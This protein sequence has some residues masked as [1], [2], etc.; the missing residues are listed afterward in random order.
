M[1]KWIVRKIV[2][3]FTHKP[4]G[5]PARS[6]EHSQSGK[7]GQSSDCSAITKVLQENEAYLKN[8]IGES[9]DIIYR[10]FQI[11]F[12]NTHALIVYVSGMVDTRVIDE[13]ILAPLMESMG[14]SEPKQFMKKSGDISM[15][16]ESGVFTSAVKTT[17]FWSEI[18]D[19]ISEGDTVLLVDQCAEALMLNTR[20]YESR[21]VSEPSTESE[22]RGPR[23]GFVENI[24]TNA[25]LIRRRIK[26][27]GLRFENMKIGERT[28]TIVSLIYIQ[29]LVNEA[30]LDEV[31]NRLGRIKT[32][33]VLGS[34]YIEEFIEDSP[35]S[36]FPL[37]ANTE[38]PDRACAAILEGRIAIL[39]DN[40]P[41]A[42]IVPAIF[43][44]FLQTSGDY[45]ER[46]TL[47]TFIRWIRFLALFLS[48]S[49]SPLYVLLTSF[50]QEMLPTA[51][52]LKI[53]AGRSG[54][55]FPAF[56][57]AFLMEIIL[58]IMKEAGLRMPKPLGQTVSIVGTLV[59]GQAAVS[60][61]LVSPLMV[62][63]IAVAAISSFAIPSYIMSNSLR[64]IR[65]PLLFLSALFGLLGYIA[66]L[67]V[68]SLHLMSLRSFGT[69]YLAPVIPF[70][71][72][73][74]VQDVFTRAPWWK[75]NKRSALARPQDQT[76]QNSN[77]LKPKP[78][79][80]EA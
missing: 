27:Y 63:V 26:D 41:F 30:L 29:S 52:A 16:V 6:A 9:F 5:S 7:I 40:T 62:I 25:A 11:P 53:A 21:A 3:W 18:C 38:R 34:Q 4:A 78:P 49:L 12:K 10:H 65:F 23:D 64:L 17:T 59:I 80:K 33:S 44:Q 48:I 72:N 73:S 2:G 61:G 14:L 50:H 20:K 60:A 75:M 8:T 13:T 67:M 24:Q 45:Y 1:F 37:V 54:V 31:R 57:E 36:I 79:K 32:D 46:F 28:K 58:E 70:N 43:W 66:G 56:V 68:I 55:P 19:A 74:S 77:D 15:L 76:R 51:L 42:L 71:S 39:V 22:I 35:Y 69:P 47:G